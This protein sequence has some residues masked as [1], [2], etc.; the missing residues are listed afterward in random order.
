M[1]E[2]IPRQKI[3]RLRR[4]LGKLYPDH[5]RQYIERLEE[6][7]GEQYKYGDVSLR[8]FGLLSDE[9]SGFGKLTLM[10]QI[11]LGFVCPDH[12]FKS[13]MTELVY[14]TLTEV[15]DFTEECS[16]LHQ[17]LRRASW[18]SP[19]ALLAVSHVNLINTLA[20]M[21]QHY[22]VGLDVIRTDPEADAILRENQTGPHGKA[23]ALIK[24]NLLDNTALCM[25]SDDQRFAKIKTAATELLKEGNVHAVQAAPHSK[26]NFDQSQQRQLVENCDPTLG[27]AELEEDPVE[28]VI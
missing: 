19:I 10:Q 22:G 8:A 17:V 3:S 4:E 15:F 7:L 14:T 2:P 1:N 23:D 20:S 5:G 11:C 28:L 9:N 27:A 26:L 12:E 6:D 13:K 18:T 21:A 24:N 25:E 16:R